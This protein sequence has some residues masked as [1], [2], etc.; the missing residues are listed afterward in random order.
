MDFIKGLPHSG[1]VDIILVVVDRLTKYAHFTGLKHPYITVT[2]AHV[3]IYQ[4][5]K[6]YGLLAFIVTD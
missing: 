1:G 3:Y 2:V 5:F 6:L 4:V